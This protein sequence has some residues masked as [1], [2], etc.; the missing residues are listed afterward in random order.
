MANLDASRIGRAGSL[1]APVTTY[2]PPSLGDEWSHFFPSTGKKDSLHIRFIPSENPRGIE[3][4]VSRC[5]ASVPAPETQAPEVSVVVKLPPPSS[6]T[7]NHIST[8]ITHHGPL[9]PGVSTVSG[10]KTWASLASTSQQ[11]WGSLPSDPPGPANMD[12]KCFV[13]V[14]R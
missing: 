14:R 4:V 9:Q 10:P 1:E 3:M 8:S 6:Q 13:K 11:K 7:Y 12:A 2:V 5:E